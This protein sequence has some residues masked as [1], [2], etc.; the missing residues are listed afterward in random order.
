[1]IF[2]YDFFFIFAQ[3]IDFEDTFRGGSNEYSY[4]VLDKLGGRPR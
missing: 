3:N 1:M 2:L 4:S